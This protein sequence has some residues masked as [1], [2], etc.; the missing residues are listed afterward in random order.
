MDKKLI[1]RELSRLALS[2]AAVITSSLLFVGCSQ[3]FYQPT[4]FAT[5]DLYADHNRDEIIKEQQAEAKARQRL[6]DQRKAYWANELGLNNDRVMSSLQDSESYN[7]P[8]GAKLAALST[9]DEYQ[10]PSSYYNLQQDET[11]N[12]L[13]KY[14]PSEYDAYINSRGNVVVEPKYVNSMYGTWGSPYYTPYAWNY[15][16]PHWGY[17]ASW[18]YPRYSWWD[19]NYN[20]GWGYNWGWGYSPYYY[21][22][23]GYPYYGYNWYRPTHRPPHWGGGYGGS[24]PSHSI[25]KRPNIYNSPSSA[26]G[27]R[28]SDGST[29]GRSTRSTY[30]R[31]GSTRS[32]NYSSPTRNSS[33]SSPSMSRPSFSSPSMSSPS[34]SRPSMP[35]RS[36]NSIGR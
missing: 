8:Y 16:Y 13:A 36:T 6:E 31:G 7:T 27:Q 20:F 22:W 23:G 14:D 26:T 21:G 30:N 15:G 5:D 9:S 33:F 18:G 10:R 2:V 28:R 29:V 25:V 35:S 17:Y 1:Q 11:L 4:T 32:S 34:M 3:A 19:Y 12:T 24:R